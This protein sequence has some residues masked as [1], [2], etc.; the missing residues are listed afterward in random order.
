MKILKK[1]LIVLVVTGTIMILGILY[2]FI[3]NSY[4][5]PW[6]HDEV[7]AITL[8]WGGLAP[9]PNTVK[10]KSFEKKGSMFSRQFVLCFEFTSEDKLQ[11]WIQRSKRLKNN[12]P[13]VNQ[14]IKTYRIY[15]GE[16]KSSGGTVTIEQRRVR[17]SM[18]WS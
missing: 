16:E 3:S 5:M 8:K 9:L 6:E 18:S 15:P 10:H 4:V 17:I 2:F 14:Q 7:Q 12:V 13:S 11:Q 1:A